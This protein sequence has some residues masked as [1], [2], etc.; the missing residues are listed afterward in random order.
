MSAQCS[1]GIYEA[2]TCSKVEYK[3]PSGGAAAF[4]TTWSFIAILVIAGVALCVYFPNNIVKPT[5]GIWKGI[6]DYFLT[7]LIAAGA[8]NSIGVLLS[9]Q[10]LYAFN[11]KQSIPSG[12]DEALA[13]GIPT[14]QKWNSINFQ[15]HIVPGMMGIGL[16]VLLGSGSIR[17]RRWIVSI[18]SA[19][20]LVL[21]MAVYLAVP[22]KDDQGKAL[23]GWNKVSFV[24]NNPS[25]FIF[26]GQLM[27]CGFLCAVVPLFMI[28]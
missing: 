19:A 18:V 8:I 24:Y 15:D 6:V 13:V 3:I 12:K 27:L 1:T 17:D 23:Y 21:F 4:Y 26:I 7:P 10:I 5:N 28:G 11:L 9:S 22:I 20:M 2:E 25:P 16:L 14:V